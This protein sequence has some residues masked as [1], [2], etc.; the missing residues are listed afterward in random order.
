MGSDAPTPRLVELRV[1]DDHVA[2][3][4]AGFVVDGDL[5]D[6]GDVG[7]RLVGRPDGEG[8]TGIVGWALSGVAAPAGHL[9]GLPTEVVDPAAPSGDGDTTVP[10]HP[11][12]CVGLD[13][14]VV[15]TPDLDRTLAALDAAGLELRRIRDTTSYGSPMRQAFFRL[16]S[17]ILEVVSGD[18]GTGRPAA[19]APARWFGLA[20]DVADLDET[21]EVL[22]EA[23]GPIKGAVQEGRRI[24]TL[25]HRD[26]GVSVAIAAMDDHAAR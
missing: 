21:A 20:V 7:V 10:A 22:G 6:L 8:P 26:L 13:H 12:G 4:D 23:L 14:V 5:V 1:A 15:L 17:V 16:G 11:N 19:D 24:A 2:W 18:A 3:R 9:D 25:R